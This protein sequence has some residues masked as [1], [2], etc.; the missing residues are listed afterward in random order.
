MKTPDLKDDQLGSLLSL[1]V[2]LLILA[3]IYLVILLPFSGRA[4]EMGGAIAGMLGLVGTIV[5]VRAW[6]QR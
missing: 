3:I 2:L 6:K 1:V 4:A 5:G